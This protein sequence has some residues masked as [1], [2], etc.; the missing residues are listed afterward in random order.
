MKASRRGLLKAGVLGLAAGATPA[1]AVAGKGPSV[2]IYDS[3]LPASRAF[4]ATATGVAK[5]DVAHQ[6]RT[7][8]RTLRGAR[9]DGTITGMTGWSDLVI[10][11]GLLEEQGKRL[12]SE[13]RHGMLFRWEMG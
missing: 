13:T 10:V 3:R 2:L 5:V 7:F 11:R 4:A 9:I 8:W 6:D 12:R 1:L